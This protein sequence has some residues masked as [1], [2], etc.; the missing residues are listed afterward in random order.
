M[1]TGINFDTTFGGNRNVTALPARGTKT[2]ARGGFR[3]ANGDYVNS[4]GQVLP[5]ANFWINIGYSAIMA[6]EDGAP[7]Q[8]V[9]I[10]LLQNLPLDTMTKLPTSSTNARYAKICAMRNELWDDVMEQAQQLKPG[11]NVVIHNESSPL[12][13][14]ILHVA[15]KIENVES[16]PDNRYVEKRAFFQLNAAG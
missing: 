10:S 2:D 15:P 9:F 11:Q 6:G 3:N 13:I 7:D 5:K 8:E 1:S 4:A 16:T 12:E 14:Q